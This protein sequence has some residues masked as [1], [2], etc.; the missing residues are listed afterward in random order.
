MTMI[1]KWKYLPEGILMDILTWLPVK[2]VVRFSLI[3]TKQ[4]PTKFYSGL[5]SEPYSASFPCLDYN[6]S[7]DDV[8]FDM[9]I[10]YRCPFHYW[11][12][13]IHILG[14]YNGLICLL[15]D[16]ELLCIW[17]PITNEYKKL[18]KIPDLVPQM[19]DLE[20]VVDVDTFGFGYDCMNG[21]YK[22]VK[23]LAPGTLG[24][25]GVLKFGFIL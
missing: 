6:I 8:T 13:Y 22:V 21:D 11:K 16:P 3:L 15:S 24:E 5:R 9:S 18:P 7:G 4:D 25:G 2:S 20:P 1:E 23:I 12:C 17:N 19:P 10:E 14:I